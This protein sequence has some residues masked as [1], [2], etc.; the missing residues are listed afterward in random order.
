MTYR[1]LPTLLIVPVLALSACGSKAKDV[2]AATYTCAQFT[3][4]LNTKGDDTSGNY[5]NQLRKK[6]DLGKDAKTEHSA[7]AQ[8][9][10]FA[11]LGQPAS[12]KPLADA[13]ANL[14]AM[15]AGTF[16]AP[17]PGAAKKKSGQ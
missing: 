14:K 17:K 12:K 7:A 8:A 10:Y 11:C 4:S 5:I 3:K 13:T 6:V 16:K 15:K 9:I 2:N 1:T